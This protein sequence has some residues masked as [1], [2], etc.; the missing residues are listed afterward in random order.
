MLK[1]KKKNIN[2]PLDL[3]DPIIICTTLSYSKDIFFLI[4]C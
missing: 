1:K 4:L 3:L 2:T